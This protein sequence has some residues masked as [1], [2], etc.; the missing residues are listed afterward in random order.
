MRR[1]VGCSTPRPVV[2]VKLELRVIFDEVFLTIVL[3]RDHSTARHPD[4]SRADQLRGMLEDPTRIVARRV[5]RV[6]DIR[7]GVQAVQTCDTGFACSHVPEPADHH[8]FRTDPGSGMEVR[9]SER[10]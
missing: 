8:N 9:R 7:G 5:Y 1:S 3:E 2:K 6:H 10:Q 4:G